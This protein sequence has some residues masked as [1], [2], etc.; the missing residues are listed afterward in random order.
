MRGGTRCTLAQHSTLLRMFLPIIARKNSRQKNQICLKII[1][2]FG[3]FS[4]FSFNFFNLDGAD[5]PS[6][7][8]HNSER[9]FV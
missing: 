3:T 4:C 5:V 7:P 1:L 6:Q 2:M 8:T 9:V